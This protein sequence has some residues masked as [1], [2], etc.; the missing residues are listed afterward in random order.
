MSTLTSRR[1]SPDVLHEQNHAVDLVQIKSQRV[2]WEILAML[3]RVT[4]AASL[5]P[6]STLTCK[7]FKGKVSHSNFK[8]AYTSG[9]NPFVRNIQGRVVPMDGGCLIQYRMEMST[10]ARLIFA[11]WFMAVMTLCV[12]KVGS[13]MMHGIAPGGYD[14]FV[15]IFLIV[16]FSF[17]VTQLLLNEGKHQEA[18]IEQ[19]LL[20]LACG[21]RTRVAV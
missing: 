12:T 7:R 20:E 11:T 2:A 16:M 6:E 17:Y 21:R 3:S 15:M 9:L 10:M 14:D 1:P 18:Q 5:R 8:L 4:E 19:F 13:A